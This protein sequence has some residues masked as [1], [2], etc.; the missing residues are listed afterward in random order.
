[1]QMERYRFKNK[2][3]T[4]AIKIIILLAIIFIA[5]KTYAQ[6][7]VEKEYLLYWE[8]DSLR[9]QWDRNSEDDLNYYNIYRMSADTSTFHCDDTTFIDSPLF[10]VDSTFYYGVTAV[11]LAGNESEM[12]KAV[13]VLRIIPIIADYDRSL[14]VD[15]YDF[16]M[17]VSMYND[18][19]MYY[20]LDHIAPINFD[21]FI[22]FVDLYNSK[23]E[24]KV[25]Q[26]DKL[27]ILKNEVN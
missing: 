3:L 4:Y 5:S 18:T 17:F 16:T 7:E 6:L 19:N 24:N 15:F 10:D 1:M 8:N 12:S 26:S 13:S 2:Y 27:V 21:D 11:D 14:H 9:L 23:V 22:L 25:L 20:D